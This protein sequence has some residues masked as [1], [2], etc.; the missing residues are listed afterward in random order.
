MS[1]ESGIP[2]YSR[3]SS[4]FTLAILYRAF[5]DFLTDPD[6]SVGLPPEEAARY[7]QKNGKP[8]TTA[9]LR[10]WLECEAY[11]RPGRKKGDKLHYNTLHSHVDKLCLLFRR[12]QNPM[13]NLL[14]R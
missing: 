4:E 11:R 3:P 8:A 5:L 2:I 6:F 14:N 10:R 13:E 1:R 7:F 9:V 12:A